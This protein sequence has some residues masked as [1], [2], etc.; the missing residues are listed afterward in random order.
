M[1]TKQGPLR[2]VKAWYRDESKHLER[3]MLALT[4]GIGYGT[5]APAALGLGPRAAVEVVVASSVVL[6]LECIK[7]TRV[8]RGL[9]VWDERPAFADEDALK[10]N[11]GFEWLAPLNMYS[12]YLACLSVASPVAFPILMSIF[13]LSDLAMCL[14]HLAALRSSATP[15]RDGAHQ[16]V[17]LLHTNRMWIVI[18]AIGAAF[19]LVCFLVVILDPVKSF[20]AGL[21]YAGGLFV[22]LLV[23]DVVANRRDFYGNLDFFGPQASVPWEDLGELE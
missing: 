11:E 16:A 7:L 15:G 5:F 10:Q 6:A 19:S 23:V 22:V 2:F 17:H 1:Q 13:C 14:L 20:L 18:D 8:S 9:K 3:C 4:A 21:L 12:L